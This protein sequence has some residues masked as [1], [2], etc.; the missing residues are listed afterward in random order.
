MPSLQTEPMVHRRRLKKR[1]HVSFVAALSSSLLLA[2]C[3]G[4]SVDEAEQLAL[5]YSGKLFT[6]APRVLDDV[7][8]QIQA[9]DNDEAVHACRV[10]DEVI[11]ETAS[12][13]LRISK[14]SH[15]GI[16]FHRRGD[17]G[18]GLRYIKQALS[19]Y[20]NRESGLQ[21]DRD[22]E[23]KLFNT[24]AFL[25]Q[26]AGNY[27]LALKYAQKNAR[28]LDA[29]WRGRAGKRITIKTV[30]VH[31]YSML[32]DIDAAESA[33]RDA[34]ESYDKVISR[35]P[36]HYLRPRW[37]GDM[38]FAQGLIAQAKGELRLAEVH[39]REALKWYK[40]TV[41]G[42][43]M[44]QKDHQVTIRGFFLVNNLIEQGR[45]AEAEVE[46][47]TALKHALLYFGRNAA[48]TSKTVM[49]LARV[50]M[51]R[52]RFED[53]T[54]LA[55]IA[56][57]I[58]IRSGASK[59][60]PYYIEATNMLAEAHLAMYDHRQALK[61][62]RENIKSINGEELALKRFI[63]AN[64]NYAISLMRDGKLSE[65][66]TVAQAADQRR[67]GVLGDDHPSVY[68]SQTMV[69]LIRAI[70]SGA[71][72]EID[73]MMMILPKYAASVHDRLA[74]QIE[75]GGLQVRFSMM[76]DQFLALMAR[77]STLTDRYTESMLKV[78][79]LAQGQKVQRALSASAARANIQDP[80]LVKLIRTEQDASY[81]IKAAYISLGNVIQGTDS[82]VSKQDL[83]GK[84]NGLREARESI[85][86]EISKRFPSYESLV[87][88]LP[89]S[90]ADIQ[91]VLRP[92]EVMLSFYFAEEQGYVFAIPNAGRVHMKVIPAKRREIEARVI[93]IRKSL[94]S[95]AQ[96]LSQIPHF[97]V[98]SAYALYSLLLQPVKSSWESAESLAIV[99]NG[100]LAS[101]PLGTLVTKPV[102][103]A[104]NNLRF[105]EYRNVPWLAKTHSIS[106]LP[107][108]L[109]ITTLRKLPAGDSKRRKFAGFGNP[110]FSQNQSNTVQ[111]ARTE[112]AVH[113]RGLRRVSGGKLDSKKL[114][115]TTLADLIVLPE[116]E[117]E[118]IEVAKA[119]RANN[120]ES[121]FLGLKANETVVKTMK[122]DDRR[123]LMF[124]THA[125]LPGDL[126]GL[127]QPAIALSSPDASSSKGDGLLTMGE[128]LGLK[129]DADWVV[130]SACNT[131]A[132]SG[133]GADAVS[134]LGMAFFYA[135]SRALL[136]THWPVETNS[137]RELTTDLFQRQTNKPEL[138]RAEAMAET[139]RDMIESGQY[140]SN[141]KAQF[142]YAHPMFWAPFTLIGDGR[143]S[144]I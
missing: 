77:K 83:L 90:V 89:A 46:S 104:K 61:A 144:R 2:G 9:A 66:L 14:L 32:G 92:Q 38:A 100:T 24:T 120:N 1:L 70:Q 36:E 115:S 87:R 16:A 7:Y 93:S 62:F 141:G 47:R 134:G 139:M 85:R 41:S 51:V 52:G 12:L 76:T 35:K 78:T 53:I 59:S 81:K 126:N 116:T 17:T 107:S 91:K 117:N 102:R 27:A 96:S 42:K 128:I 99:A 39:F 60:S 86:E 84:V 63:N 15:K 75:P 19:L 131:G 5:A 8:A 3:G 67:R 143:G 132:A 54:R 26:E 124:A 123:V 114:P 23:G 119:L 129:L 71:S 30:L 121:V 101:L 11:P 40:N 43:N 108:V 97:D 125:L 37:E 44:Y 137:A 73:S 127:E 80:A 13:S 74:D 29:N 130:L 33:L 65:A 118:I 113:V 103:L 22:A 136:V 55:E 6:P 138:S 69:N 98:A 50:M 79:Q 4:M 10:C 95:G 142:S 28:S 82:S 25:H 140:I 135:G 49:G 133:K 45:I 18:T 122:L 31:Q 109:S 88:P 20:R 48:A 34:E 72:E 106:Y 21:I 57:D 64:L 105:A 56:R 58:L 110:V 112:G 68:E 111:I 94:D